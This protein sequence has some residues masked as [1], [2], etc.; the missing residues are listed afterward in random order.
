ME[1]KNKDLVVCDGRKFCDDRFCPWKHPRFAGHSDSANDE[2]GLCRKS[3]LKYSVVLR[4]VKLD[5]VSLNYSELE[6]LKHK[7][8]ENDAS[9]NFPRRRSGAMETMSFNC[10]TSS[11]SIGGGDYETTWS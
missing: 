11:T 8:F 3:I 10:T 9:R 5:H 7:K 4:I 1:F 6:F 2:W